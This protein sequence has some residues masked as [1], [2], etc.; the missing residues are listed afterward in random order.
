MLMNIA[1]DNGCILSELESPC[2]FAIHKTRIVSR[3][4][5]H[6]IGM[7]RPSLLTFLV[8]NV[9]LHSSTGE[10]LFFRPDNDPRQ[11]III[12]VTTEE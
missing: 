4:V 12:I 9:L 2:E 3:L 7:G 8:S 6:I 5:D 10:R 1:N 11:D